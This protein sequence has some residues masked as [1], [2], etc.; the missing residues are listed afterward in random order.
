MGKN[1]NQINTSFK[2][3]NFNKFRD[4][5]Y[6]YTFLSLLSLFFIHYL[7]FGG[8][9]YTRPWYL[10]IHA[11]YHLF[12]GLS[13]CGLCMLGVLMRNQKWALLIILA[14]VPFAVF[15]IIWRRYIEDFEMLWTWEGFY[16]IF[17]ALGIIVLIGFLIAFVDVSITLSRILLQTKQKQCRSDE[18]SEE[19]KTRESIGI[20][21]GISNQQSLNCAHI[22]CKL[23]SILTKKQIL[24]LFILT[25]IVGGTG[26]LS[27]LYRNGLLFSHR[28]IT[29]TPE[30][31][32]IVFA[33][34]GD[35]NHS[36]F[37]AA[38]CEE[39][40]EHNMMMIVHSGYWIGYEKWLEDPFNWQEDITSSPHY[41]WWQDY[42]IDN[43]LYWKTNYP[44][45][46]LIVL[47][48]G[49]PCGFT[50]D[51]SVTNGTHGVGGTLWLGWEVLKTSVEYNLT[52]VVG[53]HTDQEDCMRDW[54]GLSQDFYFKNE[55]R[56]QQA[57]QNYLDFFKKLED[58]Y[59]ESEWVEF[60]GHVNSLYG[61]DHFLFTT[62]YD[63]ADGPL[64]DPLDNDLDLEV[65]SMNNVFEIPYDEFVPMLYNDDNLDP[66]TAHFSL[67]MQMQLHHLGLNKYGHGM[68]KAG[69]LLGILDEGLFM[70]DENFSQ[71]DGD[72]YQH[73][74]GFDILC[75]QILIL[76]A[77][78]CPQVTFF[79]LSDHPEGFSGIFNAYGLNALD[80][81]NDTVNGI[82]SLDSFNIKIKADSNFMSLEMS[83]DFLFSQNAHWASIYI[84]L[85]VF[86]A[87]I[88]LKPKRDRKNAT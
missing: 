5:I 47:I 48:H 62:T 9:L 72:K 55:T 78:N 26:V 53:I 51:Y 63:D 43:C 32:Q 10:T 79:T 34:Y 40:N 45:I 16:Y 57:T 74:S 84:G 25:A 15:K 52:N 38:Q 70:N 35:M 20:S 22:R 66:D 77:F 68:N 81:I 61:I 31:Y 7:I 56:N 50:T 44:N 30:D 29:I 65:F 76:K 3:A 19:S 88:S 17:L 11:G 86:N 24:T 46:R 8:Y 69:A 4:F 1:T 75:K 82:D 42:F 59:I 85:M 49:I 58:T 39:M 36:L 18:K 87:F 80:V 28:E 2:H 14:L 13:F 67:Y 60:F 37:S 23:Q 64:A 54:Y 6:L 21:K 27:I 41:I 12:L 83:Y 71:W 33:G 73:V